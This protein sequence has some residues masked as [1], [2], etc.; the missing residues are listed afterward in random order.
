VTKSKFIILS[1]MAILMLLV[2]A[3]LCPAAEDMGI[4]TGGDKGTYYQFGLDLQKLLKPGVN[5]TVHTSKG[6]IE[7]IF[8][9]YQRP[10][11]QMGIVQ[12]DVL[13][14]VARVQSDPV[15]SRIAKKTRMVFPLYNE[16][17]HLLGKKGIR[18]FDD[19][20]GKRVAIGRDG[21]G[22]YLT[23]RLLF[24]LSEV[25][26]AEMVPIDT[27]EALAEL[28]AGRIDAMFYVAGFPVKL[29]KEDVTEKDGLELIPILNKSITE[30]Y[31]RA[32][33]PANV[34]EWQRTPVNSVAVKAVLVS[35]DFR[36]KDC[37]NVGRFAQTMSKQMSWLLQNG[38]PKWKAVDLN[39]PLKGWEQYD[40]V[41]KYIGTAAAGAPAAAAKP[42]ANENPVF[43]A[44]KGLLDD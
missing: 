8:A 28:K 15:L 43:N 24:K 37:D 13:A 23:S 2:A 6:S 38:H 14:F 18:D 31:P 41:R 11:V 26:P 40:C 21:S 9:V 19:L 34:Y 3:S 17:V 35:F 33:I 16:E 25:V 32:E 39:Y 22:T 5:L 10:G 44:I 36:R 4:I 1:S 20:T 27:G 30:F 29:L 42:A 7:N 12:S